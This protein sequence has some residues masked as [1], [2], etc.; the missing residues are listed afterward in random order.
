M[1]EPGTVRIALS[2]SEPPVGDTTKELLAESSHLENLLQ[3]Q[4]L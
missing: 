2:N 1:M 4:P 3:R